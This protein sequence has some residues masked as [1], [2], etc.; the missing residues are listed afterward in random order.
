M[1]LKLAVL[2]LETDPFKHGRQIEPFAAGF[3]DGEE[4]TILWTGE[5]DTMDSP[6]ACIPRMAALLNRLTKP[7]L[8]Y[9]HNGGK[10]DWLFF[11]R[12]LRGKCRV[13]NGRLVEAHFGRHVVRDS[14]SILPV[15][16]SAFG[17]KGEIDYRKMERGVRHR[18][19]EEINAYLTQD[20]H[21][22]YAG[23]KRFHNEFGRKLTI[24]GT[25]IGRLKRTQPFVQLRA[26][27]D[28]Y[29]R[30][31]Y[32]FGGRVQCFQQGVFDAP[33][34][35]ADVNSQYPS[36]MRNVKHPIDH[37]CIG[38][39]ITRWTYFVRAVGDSRGAFVKRARDGS[40][41]FPWGV[42]EYTCSIHEW[43]TA[44]ELG[45]FSPHKVLETA[46]CYEAVTFADFVDIYYQLRMRASLAKDDM[47]KLFYK[48]I[49][50]SAYGKFAQ[51]PEKYEDYE[52]WPIDNPPLPAPW[53]PRWENAGYIIWAKAA[54]AES[55]SFNNVLTGASITGAARA[56][57]LRAICAAKRP[58]YCDTDS[59]ICESLPEGPGVKIDPNELG[60]WKIEATGDRIAV[61]GKKLYAVWKDGEPVKMAAKGVR[62]TPEQILKIASGE[63]V[64][65][66]HPTPAMKLDG[67]QVYVKRRIQ[68]T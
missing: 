8:I 62:M 40:L 10:F 11:M 15:K 44:L 61:A 3:Y 53:F 68:R 23:V 19:A 26:S 20:L 59:I 18:H 31:R 43:K 27:E 57:L 66:E 45:L 41:S 58:Y 48:L 14:Y 2:D 67:K 55:K 65:Y 50:N 6:M 17:S 32:Y 63:S 60:A 64:E 36:V 54:L 56:V 7:H 51:N 13:I 39:R 16:L 9:A 4:T 47:L 33:V 35:I 5:G 42:D 34:V 29:Y 52:I 12:Y 22:L 46:D 28:S 21:G 49:L 24:G 25:S 30:Q 37:P 38:D 1:P